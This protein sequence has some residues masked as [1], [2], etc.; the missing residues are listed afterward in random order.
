MNVLNYND[1]DLMLIMC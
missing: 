1:N